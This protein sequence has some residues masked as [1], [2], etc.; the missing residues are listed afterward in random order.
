MI[1]RPPRSTLFPYTTLFRSPD[2]RAQLPAG[3]QGRIR[4]ARDGQALDQ[5]AAG[6]GSPRVSAESASPRPASAR[7]REFRRILAEM[8]KIDRVRGGGGGAGDGPVIT[9]RLPR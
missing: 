2:P 8:L 4:A 1:R 6:A 3:R 7:A 5:L 9:S